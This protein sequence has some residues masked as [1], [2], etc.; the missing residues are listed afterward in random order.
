MADEKTIPDDGTLADTTTVDAYAAA[1]N[2]GPVIRPNGWYYKGFHFAGR[3]FWYASPRIQ[4]LMVAIV[5]FLCPGMFN[6]LGGLGGGG[7]VDPTAADHANVAL[8]STF[9]AVGFFSGTIANRFGLR[10]CLGLGSLGY[11]IYSASFLSYNHTSNVGF[12]IFAGAFLGLCAGLLWTAQGAIMMSYPIEEKKGRYISTFWII[13]NLGAVIGSLVPLAQNIHSHSGSVNDGTYVAFIVLMLAG[14]IISLFMLD[15]NKIVREDGT[16]VILMKNPSLTSEILGLWGTL[17]S[18]P[19]ILLLF[20]MFFVSNIFYTY[21]NNAMN[22]AQFNIRTRALN[23]LL[24]WLAQILGAVINGYALDYPGIRR[25]L[26]AKIAFGFLFSLTWIIWGGGYAWQHIQPPREVTSADGY[27]E[28]K[29]DWTD[30][31]KRFIGPMFLYFF[32]GFYDAIWQT[33]IY[34]YMGALSNSGRKAANMAGFYKGLQ[35]AGAAIFWRMDGIKKPF[36]TLFYSTW[37]CLAGALIFAAPVIFLKVKDHVDIEEDLKFSD[38]T[39][40]DIV[41]SKQVGGEV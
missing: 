27:E 21:Q 14:A 24:Y 1:Q 13:F 31:G 32:Y 11:C 6:A 37:G 2:A 5:C 12:V 7:Q 26:K 15:A 40:E 41:V 17:S 25:S 33:C 19:W 20:P 22:A 29:I 16:K 8:Y 39:I 35:S 28:F 38:E 34:W 9:A 18:A 30:G 36:D 23:N 4:L 3:E 10:L